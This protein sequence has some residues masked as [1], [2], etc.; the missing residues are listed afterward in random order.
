MTTEKKIKP[1]DKGGTSGGWFSRLLGGS[2]DHYTCLLPEDIGRFTSLLLKLFYSGIKV[3]KAQLE[4]IRQLEKDAIII[5]VTKFKN[6]FEYLF[7]YS[8]YRQQHLPFPQIGFDYKVYLCQPASRLLKIFLARLGF[9]FR[10]QA[11]PDPYTRG[12][13]KQELIDGRSGF[14]PLIGKKSFYRRFV[15][16]HTDPIHYLIEIQKTIDR[17]LYLIPQ[18]IFFSR[19]ARRE[20]PTLLD[21]VFGP[22]DKPGRIRRLFTLFKN[23]GKVFVE[24]SEPVS[25]KSYLQS[26]KYRQR[27]TEYQALVLRRDL[28]IQL[29][30]HRQSITG[31][32]R[33]SKEELKESIL[34]R[35]R[36]QQFMKTYAENREV[37]IQH[38]YRDA[39]VYLEEIAANYKPA[40]IK[41]ASV[42]VGWIVRTM[43][44]GVTI[45]YEVLS[46]VK[47]MSLKGPLVL[48]PCHKSHIDYL[49][50][51]YLLYQNNM[52][53]P[54]IAAGKN[55]SFWPMGPLFRS[56]GAF[57]L[58][59]SFGG[60]VLYSKVF[61]EYI[62]KL[63]EE[64]YNI[65]Q[66]I[67]G[68]RSRTGKLLMPKLGL[69]SILVNAYKDGAC[70]DMIIVPIYIGYDR[71]I[72]E[73][74]YL[75]ELGGGQKEDENLLQV[76]QARK[77][78]KKRYGKIY[79]QFHEP[80][81]M[82]QLLSRHDR[83]LAEMK[84]KEVNALVRNLGYR[85][86][87]AINRVAVA[88]PYAIV[89]GAILNTSRDTFSISELQ[90]VFDIYRR[91][92]TTQKAKLADTLVSDY[93]RTFQQ[94]ID[95]YC[96]RKFI[97]PIAKSN[98]DKSV[99]TQFSIN[100]NRRLYLEYYK[101]TCIAFF[102]PAAYTAMTIL[103]QNSF[104]FSASDLRSGYAFWQDFFGY[105]FA[106]DV[107][108]EPGYYV[109]K[110]IKAF[111][112]NGIVLPHPTLPD[113]YD[114]T[115]ACL[116][117]LNLFSLFL[118]TFLESYWIVINYYMRNPQNSVKAKDRLK[119]IGARGNRMYKR[120]EIER[121]EA[122]S[123]V[124]YQN[125]VEFFTSKGIKGS[126]DS[127]KIE[128]YADAIQKALKLM[129][130]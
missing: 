34:T 15:K 95:I 74:S 14:L 114:I 110:S 44:D 47:A 118:K 65:E 121:K 77:F 103:E 32:V 124:S 85:I 108:S 94:V 52:P 111:I 96:Q 25:L 107:D 46:Q 1:A 18:L 58:R 38:V 63:L 97:E 30:R 54:H 109:R 12:Y 82:N 33:K 92:L 37:P 78:L 6:Y 102:I 88:T 130:P 123:K 113:T 116:R 73:K 100:E 81:S 70:D 66:F 42:I 16:A 72:E 104:R 51:D 122:L 17:P 5:F 8:R 117:Q 19:T 67:E 62:Y 11:L 76:I 69:L 119:K 57:F 75:H 48:I 10:Y 98:E 2:Y 35:D 83:P 79:I 26:D 45:N 89:A 59:R 90:S 93:E 80:I 9:F 56:G 127:D 53:V 61:A 105:E 125:A 84:S 29:N 28:L 55:L 50:L 24:V 41:V 128:Y 40:F 68:G 60:A 112:D 115:P 20:N 101:N 120:K 22:E 7:Y 43:F 27:S 21:I 36:L 31:P 106:Y 3:D 87:N 91:Y 49:I 86:I 126:E 99:E 23:P 39:D 71:I 4:T 129:Q 13:I 64:G